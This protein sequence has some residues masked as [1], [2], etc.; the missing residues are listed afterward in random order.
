MKHSYHFNKSDNTRLPLLR[1]DDLMFGCPYIQIKVPSLWITILRYTKM[2]SSN[3]MGQN[4]D[5][6][7]RLFDKTKISGG[8]GSKY[9]NRRKIIM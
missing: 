9:V 6:M 4:F 5:I 2:A 7:S 3:K 8:R 1:I